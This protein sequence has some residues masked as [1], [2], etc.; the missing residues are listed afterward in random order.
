MVLVRDAALVA[1]E[2]APRAALCLFWGA[3]RSPV[4]TAGPSPGSRLLLVPCRLTTFVPDGKQ[5]YYV[6]VQ[7][8]P[9]F[10]PRSLLQLRHLHRLAAV[11]SDEGT[12]GPFPRRGANEAH[13]A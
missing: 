6:N 12:Q 3:L 7:T 4:P 8:I 2:H 13:R 9:L 10:P 11:A 5:D 1:L